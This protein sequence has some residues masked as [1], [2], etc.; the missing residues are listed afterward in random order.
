MFTHW[1]L[2]GT[3]TN[4]RQKFVSTHN[5]RQNIWSNYKAK[6]NSKKA[7]NFNICFLHSF[8]SFLQKT[9]FLRGDC[10][11]GCIPTQVSYS[12]NVFLIF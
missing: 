3:G 1:I 7:G 6:Q 9:Y 8:L 4:Y 10:T 11:I 12:P 2:K 5:P